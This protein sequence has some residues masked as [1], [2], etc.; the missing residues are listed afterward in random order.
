TGKTRPVA[1]TAKARLAFCFTSGL[2]YYQG[3]LAEF[4][5]WSRARTQAEIQQDMHRRLN[6][7]EPGL[8]SYWPLN[9]GAGAIALDQTDNANHGTIHGNPTWEP[10]TLSLADATPSQSEVISIQEPT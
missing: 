9:E 3:K 10:S 7:D 8:V 1:Q 6:G 4:Q 2:D 5:L